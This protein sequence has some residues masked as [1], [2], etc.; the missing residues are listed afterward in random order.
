M[1]RSSSINSTDSNSFLSYSSLQ[2]DLS[3]HQ[4]LLP[5]GLIPT[6]IPPRYQNFSIPHVP[7]E[8]I[9]P[10]F[11]NLIHFHWAGPCYIHTP[12]YLL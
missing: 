5:F 7:L 12:K 11:S 8:V 3:A 4:S 9:P 2:C 6:P 1:Y 10:L